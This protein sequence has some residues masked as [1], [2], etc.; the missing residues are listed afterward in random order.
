MPSVSSGCQ[1]VYPVF[2]WRNAGGWFQNRPS[3][4][5]NEIRFCSA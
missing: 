3:T 2:S 5:F 1:F 4:P